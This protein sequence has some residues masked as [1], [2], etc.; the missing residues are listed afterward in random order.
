MH[1]NRAMLERQSAWQR[2]RAGLPWEEKLR[3]ALAMR[4]VKRAL[5]RSAKAEAE[6]D[7]VGEPEATDPLIDTK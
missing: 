5:Q 3:M 6:R 7:A 2:S 4:E 1:D